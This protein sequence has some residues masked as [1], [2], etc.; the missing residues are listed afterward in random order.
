MLSGLF[1]LPVML[2][3]PPAALRYIPTDSGG[4][5]PGTKWVDNKKAIFS[6]ELHAATTVHPLD[7][8]IDAFL[9]LTANLQLGQQSVVGPLTNERSMEDD[10][11]RRSGTPWEMKLNFFFDQ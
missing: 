9:N 6:V 11:Q 10:L 5:P 1:E 7:P 4:A 2:D 8:Y 3:P